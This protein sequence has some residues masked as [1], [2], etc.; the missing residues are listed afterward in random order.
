MENINAMEDK[1]D[2]EKRLE[3]WRNCF[4]DP[5]IKPKGFVDCV[6]NNY[7]GVD[8]LIF[9]FTDYISANNFKFMMQECSVTDKNKCYIMHENDETKVVEIVKSTVCNDN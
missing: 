4:K 1:M 3:S 8:S 2:L 5:K 9:L 7:H 6:I